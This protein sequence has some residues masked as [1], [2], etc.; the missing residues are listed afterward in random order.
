MNNS[1]KFLLHKQDF[2][3]RVQLELEPSSG[4]SLTT[5]VEVSRQMAVLAA[6]PACGRPQRLFSVALHNLRATA[7]RWGHGADGLPALWEVA[8]TRTTTVFWWPVER[9]VFFHGSIKDYILGLS[10]QRWIY[11]PSSATRLGPLAI[12]L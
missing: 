2:D 12:Y 4:K 5:E 3:A 1:F 10:D 8:Q 9:N 11:P 7:S 6:F